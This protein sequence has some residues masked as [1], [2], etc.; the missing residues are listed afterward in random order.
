MSRNSIKLVVEMYGIS[1]KA[2]SHR[3][4]LAWHVNELLSIS[5][6]AISSIAISSSFH[7]SRLSCAL[8]SVPDLSTLIN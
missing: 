8:P 4:K 7:K 6:Y 1:N 3:I 5:K 2:D